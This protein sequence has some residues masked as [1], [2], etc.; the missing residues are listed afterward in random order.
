MPEYPSVIKGTR[1]IESELVFIAEVLLAPI[2]VPSF[3]LAR[4]QMPSMRIL[5]LEVA[6]GA[7]K[8]RISEQDNGQRSIGLVNEARY[9]AYGSMKFRK[10]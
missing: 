3:E 5:L 4:W 1:A 6:A 8:G 2:A 7:M 10:E 9:L